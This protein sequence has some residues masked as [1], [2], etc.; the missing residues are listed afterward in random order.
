MLLNNVEDL[1]TYLGRAV[2]SATTDE[3]LRPY[4]AQA[5]EDIFERALGA[6]FMAHLETVHADPDALEPYKQL[7]KKTQR[8][9]AWFAYLRYLPY[10]IGNDGDNGLQEIGT[11]NTNPVRI[12]VLD[13]RIRETEKN[14]V[15]SLESLLLF[16]EDNL[17][18]F[19]EYANSLTGKEARAL[20]VPS[21]TIMSD[22]L[23]QISGN[24]RLFLN[25]KPYIR[26]AE[27]DFV[28]PRIGQPQYDR[29]KTGLKDRDLTPDESELLF[30]IRRA[31][32][33]TAYWIAL[34]NMQF[35]LLGSGN[36]R[37]LSDFDGIYNSKAPDQ[38]TVMSLVRNAE[39]E[40]KKWQNALRSFLGRNITKFPLYETSQASKAQPANKLP[41][42]DNYSSIF[43]M[44]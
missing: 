29:L 4:I 12:G 26:L 11:D 27:R 34:P 16:L 31:L 22:F 33:H 18:S 30:A 7:I 17:N 41:D 8:S 37:I 20:F 42:N 15:N 28:L 9:L 36:I 40:A 14:A 24:Y 23:P 21:A 25:I 10:A 13:K 43:R 35:V 44:K 2:M 3:F 1:I 32:S 19:P 6:D 38:E 5:Q 39:S